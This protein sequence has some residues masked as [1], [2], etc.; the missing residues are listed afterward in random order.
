MI[1]PQPWCTRGFR[2]GRGRGLSL[3]RCSSLIRPIRFAGAVALECRRVRHL[4]AGIHLDLRS[5]NSNPDMR[6]SSSS[7][8]TLLPRPHLSGTCSNSAASDYNARYV[9]NLILFFDLVL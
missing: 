2:R 9:A 5:Q 7:Y 3:L 6:L 1:T 4:A 8:V